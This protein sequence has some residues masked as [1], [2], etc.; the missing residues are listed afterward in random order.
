MVCPKGYYLVEKTLQAVAQF[1]V[2]AALQPGAKTQETPR[3]AAIENLRLMAN[4]HDYGD[5]PPRLKVFALEELEL[6]QDEQLNGP[7]VMGH[8]EPVD[9]PLADP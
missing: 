1:S 5:I 2:N 4:R 7:F 3:R 8:D 6:E 9:R